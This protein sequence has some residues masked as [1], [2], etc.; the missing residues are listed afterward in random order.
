MVVSR[1]GPDTLARMPGQGVPG[2]PR[3]LG[4]VVQTGI[5]A[6]GAL[7]ELHDVSY[8][9]LLLGLRLPPAAGVLWSLTCCSD[10]V[11]IDPS[12]PLFAGAGQCVGDCSTHVAGMA[13]GLGV[14]GCG[15]ALWGSPGCCRPGSHNGLQ[16]PA[17]GVLRGPLSGRLDDG[18][19]VAVVRS[20][21]RVMADSQPGGT[22]ILG[23]RD[24]R[25]QPGVVLPPLVPWAA[26]CGGGWWP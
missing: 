26:F 12:R 5:L 21:G 9:R 22:V 23:G 18:V 11:N 14:V 17:R 15:T 6:G 19:R 16:L 8:I 13:A 20:R 4:V 10:L 1:G 7:V 2:V 25:C 24:G 3:E